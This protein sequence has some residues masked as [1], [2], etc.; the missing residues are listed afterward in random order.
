MGTLLIKGG[1][2]LDPSQ[3]LDQVADILIEDGLIGAIDKDLSEASADTVVDVAGALVTPG[4][5]DMHVHLREPGRED[6]ETIYTGTR[7]A[8]AGGFTSICPMPNTKPVIDSQSGVNHIRQIAH[9]DAAIHLYPVA[10][11]TVGQLGEEIVEFGDIYKHGAVAFSDDGRAIM[12]AEIMRRALQYVSMFDLPILAHEEDYNLSANGAIHEGHVSTLTGLKGIPS[13]AEAIQIARDIELADFTHA[14]LHIQH[15]SSLYSVEL[16][17]TSKRR[18]VNVTSEVTPH[19]LTLTETACLDF[20]TN[21][22]MSPPLRSEADRRALIEA[23]NDGVIEIIATDHAPHTV[24]EKDLPFTEAPNGVIGMETAFPVLYTELVLTGQVAL[25]TVVR[26]MTIAPAQRLQIPG[27]TLTPGS[28]ADLTVFDLGA[29][30]EVNPDAFFSKARNCPW[31]GRRLRGWPILTIVC[32]D[33][34]YREGEM[35]V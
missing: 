18:R 22:K 31:N 17:R 27:G 35:L 26:A 19:H 34:I 10:A 4:L 30:R 2:I 3:N 23:L 16:L 15:V 28:V 5:V 9:R 29:E 14:K 12:N 24:I 1:H 13:C 25:P 7:A 11:V 20:N 32:G 8:A 33:I 6:A 21:A